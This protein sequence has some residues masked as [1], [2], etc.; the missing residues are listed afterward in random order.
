MVKMVV[1]VRA[2]RKK[3][4]GGRGR[5]RRRRR[6]IVVGLETMT[7]TMVVRAGGGGG[8]Y[9]V[10]RAQWGEEGE[11]AEQGTWERCLGTVCR[12]FF[13]CGRVLYG[14]GRK[15]VRRRERRQGARRDESCK[16]CVFVQSLSYVSRAI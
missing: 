3:R 12:C 1:A 7:T 6:M 15:A 14:R 10:P 16:M 4:E 11:E 8:L 13:S 2:R 9:F 5:R